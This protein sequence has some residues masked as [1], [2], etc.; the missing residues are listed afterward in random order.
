MH[1]YS[2]LHSNRP[3]TG[4][5]RAPDRDMTRNRGCPAG[6]TVVKLSSPI[7]V[8]A[9]HAVSDTEIRALRDERS[10]TQSR[11]A[12]LAGITRNDLSRLEN[13]QAADLAGALNLLVALGIGGNDGRRSA[14]LP[15]TPSPPAGG[16]RS[17]ASGSGRRCTPTWTTVPRP[18]ASDR[19]ARAGRAA[20]LRRS[21]ARRRRA[22]P[23]PRAARRV[24]CAG[25]RT[26]VPHGHGRCWR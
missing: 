26:L 4:I 8:T 16:T 9:G 15:A 23:A 21:P 18:S 7:A 19:R 22:I 13:G 12:R 10:W 24:T 25:A 2:A 3:C 1:R 5:A 11:L 20:G 14:R 6:V 17:S